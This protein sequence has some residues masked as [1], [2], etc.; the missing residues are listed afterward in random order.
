MD[1]GHCWN[2]INLSRPMNNKGI[3]KCWFGVWEQRVRRPLWEIHLWSCP[4]ALN[5]NYA[6]QKRSE[7]KPHAADS[8]IHHAMLFDLKRL[9]FIN[10]FVI[11]SAVL[12]REIIRCRRLFPSEVRGWGGGGFVPCSQA[13]PQDRCLISHGLEFGLSTWRTASPCRHSAKLFDL[14]RVFFIN[15]YHACFSH[16][17]ASNWTWLT[18]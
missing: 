11:L 5:A 4:V 14:K 17:R 9:F 6:I 3:K 2:H 1:F 7:T 18:H 8:A 13:L 10:N 16:F 15:I 12:T